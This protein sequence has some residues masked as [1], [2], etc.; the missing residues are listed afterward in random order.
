MKTISLAGPWR[1]RS[2][3]GRT[4]APATVPGCVH[5]DLTAAGLIGDPFYR[6]NVTRDARVYG[7]DYIYSRSFEAPEDF[8]RAG[9]ALLECDGLDT[10]CRITLNGQRVAETKNMFRRY[11][12][13]VTEL[14]RP[15][16][17]EIEIY[18][19]SSAEYCRRHAGENRGAN[20]SFS[21]PGSEQ[22][23]KAVYQSGW[24]WAPQLPTMGIW[25][26][27]RLSAYEAVRLGD[28]FVRTE[29]APD[30][31]SCR[32]EARVFC[33]EFAPGAA[34]TA[35]LFAPG[36]ELLEEKEM[37]GARAVFE[38][39]APELWYPAG[40]GPQPLYRLRVRAEMAGRLLA[41]REISVGLRQ[42]EVVR[43]KDRWGV[44]FYLRVNGRPLFAK[45]ADWVPAD[46][47]PSRL[48]EEDYARLL[49]SAAECHV[50][51]LRAWGGAYY[52]KD[53]FY[54][55]CDRLG[56]LVWQDFM[57]ACCHYPM[58][59]ELR[60]EYAAEARDNV[61]RLQHHPC[62]ALWCG[63]N[64]LEMFLAGGSWPTRETNEECRRDYRELFYHLLKDLCARE[65]P[66]RTYLP[67]SPFD[68]E[69]GDPN[70][71]TSGD[72]HYWDVW[73]G[74]KPY[75]FYRTLYPRFM[76]E[77]GLQSWPS[78]E[79][80]RRV[81]LPEDRQV[82]SRVMHVLQKDLCGDQDLMYYVGAYFRMP[83]D[84]EAFVYVSQLVHAE[85]MKCGVEHWRRNMND[86]RC[87]GALVW[88]LNDCAPVISG[89]AMEYGGRWKALMYHMKEF[90]APV[91]LS[92]EEEG[93]RVRVHL[94][95][96]TAD[97]A[98]RTAELGL[99]DTDGRLLWSRTVEGEA[100]PM[101]SRCI[102]DKD[103]GEMLEGDAR[104]S[105]F[106]TAGLAGAGSLQTVLFVPPQHFEPGRPGITAEFREGRLAVT[107][108]LPAFWAYVHVP[109]TNLRTDANF[110]T[111][112]PGRERL[113]E[114]KDPDGLTEEEILSRLRVY[115]LRDSY[116]DF[117]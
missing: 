78:L 24:D 92:A 45:G 79:L 6:D 21:L 70:S 41:D 77:F 80:V 18:I 61:R 10:L 81:S 8:C 20:L 85:A 53:V 57:Y 104:R 112:L 117:R 106:F 97:K 43:D 30:Y 33:D 76:S 116:E 74:R 34:L 95:N 40:M 66:T 107:S 67:A 17:N 90:F 39:S 3:D 65:D 94:T 102:F 72:M 23:R 48:G 46:Q 101:T 11:A 47:F 22:L 14:L 35:S 111:L 27:I 93:T 54:D 86:R 12:F 52:E 68:D 69:G 91:L 29:F 100:E 25:Q 64:E 82:F 55:L 56:I 44:S 58:T 71:E 50:N 96:D 5:T 2:A 83:R 28:V 38:L 103:F 115:T 110:V 42:V 89:A 108:D 4:E 19:A 49:S 51:T 31:G 88:Q 59:E 13:D 114:V 109:G 1:L 62:V 7:E 60:E 113:F 75:A 26:D 16:T 36:G 87:M 37:T 63:N 105:R 99:W 84:F 9:R 98:V 32:L 15:G 73:H